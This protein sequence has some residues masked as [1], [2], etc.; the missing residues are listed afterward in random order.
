MQDRAQ[1]GENLCHVAATLDR[2]LAFSDIVPTWLF[3]QEA[4]GL[5]GFFPFSIAVY[6]GA[7]T[8]NDSDFRND[9]IGEIKLWRLRQRKK[10]ETF[11][12]NKTSEWI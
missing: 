9:G 1:S 8:V 6:N 12:R 5:C 3:R 2:C 11:S 7:G 10:P 4:A